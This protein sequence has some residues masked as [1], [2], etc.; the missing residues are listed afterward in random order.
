MMKG[1][2]FFKFRKTDLFYNFL[3][4]FRY[5]GPISGKIGFVEVLDYL[6]KRDL[7]G[8]RANQRVLNKG[9]LTLL[10][11]FLRLPGW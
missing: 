4:L 7:E 8:T 1:L 10:N 2:G 6:R 9:L 11:H 3:Y 5:F